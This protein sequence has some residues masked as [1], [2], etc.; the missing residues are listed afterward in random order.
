MLAGS[1]GATFDISGYSIIPEFRFGVVGSSITDWQ[2]NEEG[3]KMD[4]MPG[5][6]GFTVKVCKTF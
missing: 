3:V 5:M 6:V 1:I 4:R 2:P